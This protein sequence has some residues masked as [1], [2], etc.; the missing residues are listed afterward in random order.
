MRAMLDRDASYDGLFYVCVRTTR[1]FC[2]PSCP[3]RKPLPGNVVFHA[4]VRDCLLNGFRPCKRCRPLAGGD[5]G[6]EWLDVLIA[7]VENAPA[8]R[9]PDCV[10]RDLGV[11]PHA[12]RRYFRKS[13][14]MTFQAYHRA[15][16]MGLALERLEHGDDPL[17]VG[18]DHGWESQSAFRAAFER[19]FGTT[20][21]RSRG[22]TCIRTARLETPIGPVVAGATDE[23]VCLLEFA[24]RRAL[25]RQV[26]TLKRLLGGAIVPGRHEHLDRLRA[27]LAEYFSGVR[28]EFDVPLVTPGTEFQQ[29]VWAQLRAIPCGQTRS[30]EWIAQKLG[31][32]DARRAV[33]RAN[34]DN[35]IAIVIPCHR[36]VG[37]DGSLTGYGGGLWRKQHLLELEQTPELLPGVR[38]AAGSPGIRAPSP[39]ACAGAAGR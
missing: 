16:R 29:A 27:Q 4:A 23:G 5:G 28:R 32:P 3:A 24:D 36:V 19:T 2:R 6:P 33:G 34:G 10:L 9:L 21:G 15:R 11:D 17:A 35:R 18:P 30:Y 26:A 1:I 13:F 20:P 31:R 22:V 37:A 8:E 25:E 39:R 7:A 38:A 14:G 12:T